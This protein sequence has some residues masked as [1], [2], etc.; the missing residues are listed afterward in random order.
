V[1]GRLIPL[2]QEDESTYEFEDNVTGGRIPGEY[3]PAVNK[4]FQAAMK[5]GPLAGY[6]IVGCKM[7]LDDG[8]YHAVDSSEMAFRIAGRDAFIEAF[9][10]SRPCLLEPIMRVEVEMPREY[11]GPIVGDLNSRRGIILE[12]E[13]REHYTVVRAEVPLSN[14]FGYATVVRGLS[15][16]MATFTMEMSRYA[17]VPVRL[18]EEI[19]LQ[20]REKEQQLARK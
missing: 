12:T 10:K 13:A 3:I 15:K 20:R 2:T 11:Q 4:G 8:S 1:I 9:R 14:M 6:E 7:C 19:I 5:K 16:G 17:Q 18:A